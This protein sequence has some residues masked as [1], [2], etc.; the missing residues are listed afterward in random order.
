MFSVMEFGFGT[1]LNFLTLATELRRAGI[2][3]RVRFLSVEKYPLSVEDTARALR[4]FKAE[5]TLFD[6]F[7]AKLPPPVPGWHRRY[8]LD[9]RLELLLCYDDVQSALQDVT[10]TDQRGIDAWFLDGFVPDANPDMWHSELFQ[11]LV[12]VT[13]AE[14]TITTFTAAGHVRRALQNVGFE[15]QR[16]EGEPGRKRHTTAARLT[17]SR[18]HPQEPPSSVR[19]VGGGIAGATVAATLARKGVEVQL[20]ERSPR[21]GAGT[22]AI[23]A[24]IQHPRL[25]AADTLLA[26]FRVHAYAHAQAE[27]INQPAVA[28]VGAFH[29]PDDGM[30]IERL[31]A[32]S[33]LLGNEWVTLR[34]IETADGLISIG[35][36]VAWFPRSSVIN[37]S[38][39]C[40]DLLTHPRIEKSNQVEFG[41]SDIDD[42]PTIFA[43][44]SDIPAEIDG[45]PIEA[46]VIPGQVDAF[47]VSKPAPALN[48]IVARDGYVAPQNDM[49]WVGSTY[50]YTPWPNGTATATNRARV[51][52]LLPDSELHHRMSFRSNRVV[53]SDR[54][55]IAGQTSSNRW[56]TWAHGSGGTVTAPFVAELIAG[57]VLSELP[58]G[59]PSMSRLLDPIRFALRQRRRPNPLTRRFQRGSQQP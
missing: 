6:D 18:F 24:A 14:G 19:V 23:P 59:T 58:A 45:W 47:E 20:C 29:L 56:V 40:I 34:E 2:Q 46:I 1:G 52:R 44:G 36:R 48:N 38:Q 5:L 25:S 8:F 31:T 12:A 43:T 54:L 41:F 17:A 4:P 27:L 53:S 3:N 10:A 42:V 32:V 51:Q 49:L 16:V 57:D 11:K 26:L 50:E 37:G 15:V 39:L 22:S 33:Q 9:G 35:N 28:T 30:S 21:V 55:P 13:N 7:I